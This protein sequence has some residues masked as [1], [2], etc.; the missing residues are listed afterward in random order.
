MLWY[1]TWLETRW[2]FIIGLVLLICSASASILTYP[3]VSKLLPTAEAMQF[4]GP[5]GARVREAIEMSQT[6]DGYVWSH[7]VRQ[8]FLNLWTIFA[9]L[10]GAGGLISRDGGGGVL[11][12]M[13]LPVSRERLLTSRVLT[14]LAEL[15]ALALVPQLLIPLMSASVGQHYSVGDSLVYGLCMFAAGAVFFSLT[16][17]LS[18]TFADIWRPL[19]L[20]LGVAFV[21][22][23][24][25]E[26]TRSVG[27]YGIGIF[28]TMAGG[29]YF[30]GGGIPWIGLLASAM[31]SSA[32]LFMAS[33]N[34]SRHD[35]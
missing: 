12:T 22:A 23:V 8:N 7:W 32:L 17:L 10:I 29:S 30:S 26:L 20:V 13:S 33:L 5:L 18:T 28:A 25:E 34:L 21:A 1:K 16:V 24:F 6:F 3:M 15:L 2:R 11:F 4:S 31:A 14:G 27:S 19:I 9:V 35:F